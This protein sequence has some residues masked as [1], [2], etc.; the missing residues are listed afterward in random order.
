MK[1]VDVNDSDINKVNNPRVQRKEMTD[2]EIIQKSINPSGSP[3]ASQIQNNN[4]ISS[5]LNN[6]FLDNSNYYS[7]E[8]LPSRGLLYKKGTQISGRPLKVLE[9]KKLA[10]LNEFNADFIVN[11]ILRRT[12]RG[13]KIE[14]ILI[15]DKL[16]IILWLRANTYRDS[17]YVVDFT[18]TKCQQESQYHFELDNL[19]VKNLSESYN[20]NKEITLAS[21]QKVQVKFL[22]IGDELKINRFKEINVKA[23]GEIDNELLNIAAMLENVNNQEMSLME[24]YY[25]IT[26]MDPGDFSYLASYIEECGMGIKPY[27]SVKCSN[28]G[29]TGPVGIS[30]RGDFF[31][32]KYKFE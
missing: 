14:D 18:C 15:A 23:V 29:G 17:G 3:V 10:S 6:S 28:C 7:I 12:I 22:T 32:P 21:G 8:G 31:L 2:E 26:N 9:V 30:F 19:E 20:P 4:D 16:F 24:K 11:D 13:I 25:W 27:I 1:M 5:D